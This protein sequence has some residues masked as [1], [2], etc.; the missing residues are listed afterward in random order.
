MALYLHPLLSREL[1]ILF[2]IWQ[3]EI[4]TTFTCKKETYTIQRRIRKHFFQPFKLVN[5]TSCTEMLHNK[6][7]RKEL[8]A[9]F[10]SKIGGDALGK[11]P[12]PLA[13]AQLIHY[14]TT[15]VETGNPVLRGKSSFFFCRR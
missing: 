10:A 6:F 3:L 4:D 2:Q 13:T 14:P 12:C 11:Q 15:E 9:Y 7:T 1:G 8:E 5:I